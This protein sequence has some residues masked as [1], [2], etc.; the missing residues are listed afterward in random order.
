[1]FALVLLFQLVTYHIFSIISPGAYKQKSA[2]LSSYLCW[3]MSIYMFA[4][5]LLFQLVTYHIFSIISPGAYKQ[6]SA[7]LSNLTNLIALRL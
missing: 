4:L 3:Y 6:K 5:V 7:F 1:M 2:L